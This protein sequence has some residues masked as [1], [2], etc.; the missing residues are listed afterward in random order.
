MIAGL[1][2]RTIALGALAWAAVL[3]WAVDAEAA[4][5]GTHHVQEVCRTLTDDANY[6]VR[7]QAALVLGKMG[8]VAATP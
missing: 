2:P 8:D 7:T 3:V 5:S 6:K 1:R 4:P